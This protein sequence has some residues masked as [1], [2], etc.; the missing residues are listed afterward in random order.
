MN[1][2]AQ[3][4]AD[5]EALRERTPETQDLYREVCTILF[6]RYGIT[7][8]ANK[9]YQYVRK[10]SMSAPAEALAKFWEDLREKSRVRIEHP[11]LPEALKTAAGDLVASLWAQAQAAAQEGLA[12]F[13]AEAQ[14]TAQ[15]AK[16]EKA[17][18]ETELIRVQEEVNKAHHAIQIATERA[19]Q[20]ERNLAT[21]Q[22]GK[23][24]LADQL[25]AA[26]HQQKL[27]EAAL[28]ESRRDF[29]AELEK[30]RQ[31]LQKSEQRHEAGEKRALLEIDR[32]RTASAKL[33]KELSHLRE[34]QIDATERH[35]SEVGLLQKELAVARQIAGVA[36]GALQEMRTIYQQQAEQ[37]E[38]LQTAMLQGETQKT[39]L[40]RDLKICR[41]KVISLEQEPR[42]LSPTPAGNESAKPRRKSR[43]QLSNDQEVS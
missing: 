29:A 7:P 19:L 14:A 31:A 34:S 13:R 25:V 24:L 20:L 6:F 18:V 30:L 40:E 10:G 15:E 2:E 8:T 42:Q 21:E 41:K 9:L 5:I 33:Q 11:D 1:T 3:I 23:A 22:A 35:H 43:K 12:A 39:L 26:G 17:E 36:E 27:L 4:H 32:E 28:A 38:S 37:L 16:T